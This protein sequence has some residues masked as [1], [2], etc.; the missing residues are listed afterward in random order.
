MVSDTNLRAAAPL[1][2]EGLIGLAYPGPS[3]NRQRLKLTRLP[4]FIALWFSADANVPIIG[5]FDGGKRF[6]CTMYWDAFP[7]F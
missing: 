4:S 6:T 7:K 3:G 2:S 1:S 5:A